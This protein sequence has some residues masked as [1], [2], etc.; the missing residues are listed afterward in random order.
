MGT[1]EYCGKNRFIV[2][3]NMDVAGGRIVV[4]RAVS[5]KTT[6][7]IDLII[8]ILEEFIEPLVRPHKKREFF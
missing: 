5:I 2:P 6:L 1:Q 3:I 7:L 4:R 8:Q